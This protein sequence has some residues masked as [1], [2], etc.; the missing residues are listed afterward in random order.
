MSITKFPNTGIRVGSRRWFLQTGL[1]SLAALPLAGFAPAASVAPGNKKKAVVLFWLS[2]G[3]SHIDMWDPKPDAPAEVRGPFST[4]QTTIP[5]VRFSE[6]LP[7]QASIAHKLSILRSVDCKASNH[8]PIT[9]QAGNNL[10]RRVDSNRDGDGWPSMGS[11][12]AKFHGSNDPSLPPFVALADSLKADVW[13]AGHMGG[14]FEPIQGSTLAGRLNLPDGLN[15]ESLRDRDGL[16][17]GFDKLQRTFDANGTLEKMDQSNAQAMDLVLTGKAKQAFDLD[18]ESEKLR[19]TYGRDS[20]GEKALL[21]RRLIEAGVTF[22]VV[23]G[24]WGYFDHH[25]DEVKWGGIVKGL[26]PL[27]PRVDRVLHT[28][29]SDLEARGLSESTLVY[30]MG[31]FGRGPTINKNAGRDHWTNVMS[32]LAYGGEMP[33]GKVIGAT[34]SKGY[35]IKENPIASSNLAASVFDHLDINLQSSWMDPTGRPRPIIT[36]DA[37]TVSQ[38]S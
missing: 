5:G 31:E 7:L 12:A 2:G 9:M 32:M 23:S 34:D 18:K 21:A 11:I 37:R 20:I 1:G 14:A 38:L 22:I 29:I 24:A 30:M 3:P 10:A 36:G 8:T 17:Q 19:D 27:L 13:G 35:G 15:I 6:H 26:K 25:G 4:I 33:K 16:R 28:F